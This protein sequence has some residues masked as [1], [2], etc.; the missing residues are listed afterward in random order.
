MPVLPAATWILALNLGKALLYGIQLVL[1]VYIG[2]LLIISGDFTVGMLFAFMTYRLNFVERVAGLVLKGNEF[3]LLGLHLERLADIVHTEQENVLAPGRHSGPRVTRCH[4]TQK[5]HLS[6]RRERRASVQRAQ[7][8]NKPWR[9]CRYHRPLWW[10]QD[11]SSEDHIGVSSA[12]GRR[13][14]G[15]W[16][17]VASIR[18]QNVSRAVRSSNAG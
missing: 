1:V 16:N 12:R 5:C 18:T 2:A 15:R 6:L 13:S 10:R 8:E 14:S 4:R 3:R 11:D 17:A 7:L 9:I